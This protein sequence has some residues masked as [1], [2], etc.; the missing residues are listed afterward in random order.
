MDGLQFYR[1]KQV[2][3]KCSLKRKVNRNSPINTGIGIEYI[4]CRCKK[5]N[6]IYT[7]GNIQCI[8]CD[9]RILEK[10]CTDKKTVQAI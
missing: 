3:K 2:P 6:T 5:V 10:P 8:H 9:W 4:C 1:L 7:Q